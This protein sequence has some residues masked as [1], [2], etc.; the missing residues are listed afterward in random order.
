MPP[1]TKAEILCSLLAAEAAAARHYTSRPATPAG[2]LRSR[3]TRRPKASAAVPAA[4]AAAKR[5]HCPRPRPAALGSM[6]STRNGG[7]AAGTE[8][9]AP[10]AY[11]GG[12]VPSSS[13]C[14]GGSAA[15]GTEPEPLGRGRGG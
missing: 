3:A 9:A 6:P 11:G 10:L 15:V 1:A 5:L 14:G 7:Y 12:A 4:Y 13:S 8:G 2:C